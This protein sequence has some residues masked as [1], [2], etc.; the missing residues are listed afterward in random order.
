MLILFMLVF[1][2]V[3]GLFLGAPIFSAQGLPQRFRVAL[4]ITIAGAL[5]PIARPPQ[6]PPDGYAVVV[7]LGGE[8]A[9]GFALGLLA[10]LLLTGFQLAGA[11]ISFQMGLAMARSF[12]PS[13][14]AQVPVIA[15]VQ[16]QLVTLLFLVVDGHHVLIQGVAASY[17]MFPIGTPLAAGVLSQSLFAASAVMF[18]AGA[19]IAGPV[20][21]VMLLINTLIGFLNRIVPQLSIFNIGFP[22]TVMSGLVAVALSIPEVVAYFLRAYEGFEEQ[23]AALLTG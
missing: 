13:S 12:D 21:A 16:L 8:L 3:G 10:R 22:L 19:R 2:R 1:A 17:Q 7:A 18:E 11:L 6:L 14:G 15:T 23:I 20:T 5:M 9:V 4:A